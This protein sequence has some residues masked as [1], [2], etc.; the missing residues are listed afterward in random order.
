MP[1]EPFGDLERFGEILCR[2]PAIG[3]VRDHPVHRAAVVVM[4][5]YR[6]EMQATREPAI[7]LLAAEAGIA[8]P[9]GAD[10]HEFQGRRCQVLFQIS[11][12]ADMTHDA[13]KVD[14]EKRK[15]CCLA[16]K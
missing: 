10:R 8:D 2:N 1:C 16:R 3:H 13:S 7:P 6:L 11:K 9:G 14:T 12:I 4:G 15:N 5:V